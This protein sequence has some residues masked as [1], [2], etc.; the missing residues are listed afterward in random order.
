[1]E[2]ESV[3]EGGQ[4]K[5][6]LTFIEWQSETPFAVCGHLSSEPEEVLAVHLLSCYYSLSTSATGWTDVQQGVTERKC[7]IDSTD[8]NR[9]LSFGGFQSPLL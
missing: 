5:C 4:R 1:M 3:A 8:N 7:L 2:H 9:S 6:L